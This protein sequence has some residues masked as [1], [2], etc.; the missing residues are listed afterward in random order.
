MW[1]MANPDAVAAP[2][3]SKGTITGTVT[4]DG[5]PAAGATVRLYGEGGIDYLAETTT[6]SSGNYRFR[7]VRAGDYSVVATALST[8]LT[9]HG[10]AP[11]TVVG[12]QTTVV[13]VA[14]TCQV[15][16]P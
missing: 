8:N 10:S 6:D 9:C 11:A 12:G 5:S 1:L 7:R 16:P 3:N 15:F 2:P 4:R 14:M 13:N